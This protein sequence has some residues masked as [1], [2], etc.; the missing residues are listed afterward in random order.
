MTHHDITDKINSE[1]LRA[2]LL[3][4][5]LPAALLFLAGRASV[6]GM[7]PFGV[8]FF[9]ACFDKSIAYIGI[10]ALIISLFTSAGRYMA[11]KY[12][13]AALVFWIYTRFKRKD[14]LVWD[15][16]ACG[17]SMVL[18]GLVFLT[19]GF[20]G[21]YDVLMLLVEGIVT[22]MMYIIFSKAKSF[23]VNRKT[24]TRTAQDELVSIAVSAGVFITGLSGVVFPK[25][26]SLADILSVYAT[27]CIAL[28]TSLA[29]AGSGGLC[30]GFLASMSSP[31][32]VVTM[33][34]FGISAL[35]AN[36]LKSFGRFGVA[37]GFV[38]GSAVALLYAGNTFELPVSIAEAVIGAALFALTPLRYH[39]MIEEIF[40]NSSKIETLSTDTRAKA[41]LTMRLEKASNAF[42]SLEECF[43]NATQKRLKSYG[44]DV[45]QLLDETAD[46]VCEGCPNAVK[47]WQNDFTRTYRGIMQLLETMENQGMLALDNVPPS[48][49]EKCVRTELFVVEFN[50]I[51]ELYKKNLVRMG[52][53]V[54]GRDLVARQYRDVAA[55]MDEMAGT[56]TAGFDFRENAEEEIT[57]ELDKLGIAAYEV[58]VIEGGDGRME[59]YMS[60]NKPAETSQI[61]AVLEQVLETPMLY[62]GENVGTLMRFVSKARYSVDIGIKQMTRDFSEVSGDCV[63]SFSAGS[64][65][66]YIIISDGMGSG[67][68]A[69][70]ES[71]ITLGLLKEFL[72]SGFGVRTAVDMINS[73]L[74]LK[75]D[76]ECFS[77]VDIL[78]VD[79]MTGI[80][81]FFKIGS[82]ESV[83]MHGANVETVFSVS[84]P[85]GM[86]ADVHTEGQAKRLSG[87]DTILMMTDGV[88]EA[89]FGARTDWIK[90]EIQKPYIVMDDMAQA[91]LEMAIKKSR[92]NVV[93]DMTVAAVRLI[94]N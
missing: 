61:T 22:G 35:F 38:G 4:D 78:C 2:P 45:A 15:A 36:L 93:D 54:Q 11:V 65:K 46:R 20:T 21:M 19:Y 63:D 29:A 50:H 42:K 72:I 41:Y 70:N 89:G 52:E 85:V 24:R 83:I 18:G 13:V 10:T 26:V 3:V 77:T 28:H 87:G 34:I 8:A 69:M 51:Y 82:A 53:A 79:L 71:R 56:I 92:D 74:C 58:S 55:L 84:L 81:E 31:S 60:V 59:V 90:Q 16:A 1:M 6:L 25:G 32:A 12:L 94:E 40:T 33:G 43:E 14:S 44:K 57:T 47:C 62:D 68:R 73:A 5:A 86:V 64:Y 67:R 27:L 9:A 48:F 39:N 49:R 80:C 66:H 17:G 30:I 7:F 37:L 23:M 75:L 88:S 91:V 76:Y